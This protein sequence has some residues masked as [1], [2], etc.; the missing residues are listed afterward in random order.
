MTTGQSV[1]LPSADP[2][3]VASA[4]EAASAGTGDM[5]GVMV[6]E[7]SAPDLSALVEA[8]R[9]TGIS[10]FGGLFPSL[11]VGHEKR[12][13]GALIF[14]LPKL[15]EP[16][17]VRALDSERF[18]IPDAL[19]FVHGH[20]GAKPTAV[21]LVDGLAPNISLFLRAIYHQLGNRVSY[22]GGGAGS[23]ALRPRPCV[24]T[25]EGVHQGAGIIALSSMPARLGV[26]HGWR[27]LKGPFVATRSS[28]NVIIQLNWKNAFE[29]YR[30]TVEAD[31]GL[32]ITPDNFLR[33][34]SGYP[35]G[36]R[37]EGQ[38][39]VVRDPLALGEGGR[40]ICVGDV[41]ENCALSILKGEPRL[42][43]AAAGQAAREA[44][45]DG[46]DFVSGTLGGFPN[47]P[48]TG[49][50]EQAR[51]R[52][53]RG[54]VRH[55]LLADCVSRALF[56]GDRFTEELHAI[57]DGL[58]GAASDRKPMG[59]LTLGEISSHGEGYLEFFNKTSVV[60]VVHEP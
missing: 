26:R 5:V 56:L 18:I 37:K 36:I 19:P 47:P 39:V 29:V 1:Y 46:D 59:M 9:A 50:G 11:I 22:W 42:L 30:A 31:A 38:E 3:L 8:L 21:V 55:C 40:L 49:S 13:E 25:R 28:G 33:V 60:A 57:E 23:L 34:A 2:R 45:A 58:G 14:A 4:V 48:A 15:T 7:T 43:V 35:F 24:F 32:T 16:I 27:E 20:R 51:L 52:P 17:L 10:F 44:R 54:A 53:T 12:D 6:A 41:P